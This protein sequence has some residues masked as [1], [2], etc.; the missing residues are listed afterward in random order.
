MDI[1]QVI[2]RLILDFRLARGGPE[3]P[4]E[5]PLIP[6]DLCQNNSPL[7]TSHVKSN[8]DDVIKYRNLM[9]SKGMYHSVL[10]P[11]ILAPLLVLLDLTF[12]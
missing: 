9:Y 6:N 8:L 2:Q 11:T 10:R 7:Q 5:S 3:Q 4:G 1:R 12:C